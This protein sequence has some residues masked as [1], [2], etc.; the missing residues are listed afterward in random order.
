MKLET[1]KDRIAKAEDFITKKE[2]T[3]LNKTELIAK[4]NAKIAAET[5]ENEKRWLEYDVKHLSEDISRL[6]DEIA[7]RRAS[8]EKYK[9][10]LTT[11]TE[12]AA[13][14]N[15]PAIVE[16]LNNWKQRVFDYYNA[17][18]VPCYELKAHV[19]ELGAKV[20]NFRYMTPEYDAAYAEYSKAWQEFHDK[21]CGIFEEQEVVNKW[22]R[23]E[24]RKVKVEPG[25]YEYLRPYDCRDNYDD[26]VSRLRRDIDEEANRKYDFIIE[27][28]NA[29]CG[30][31]TD[32]SGLSVG[33]KD[34]LNGEIIGERGV[35]YVQTI[36]A[37]GWNIQ[38][39]HFRT[40]IHEV[41]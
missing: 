15:V 18:L 16:F 40:L 20:R 29:I 4:K 25:E 7:D 11:E 27:R 2:N 22:G 41:K 3:I 33:A 37:G 9:A 8:L 12:K 24:T 32:A 1:L 39:F 30:K 34:D 28:V 6:N 36:G 26:A 19:A 38:C 14:R 17:G 31:I 5:D 13:S 23:K 35:A 21:T 10:E